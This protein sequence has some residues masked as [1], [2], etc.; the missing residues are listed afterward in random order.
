M[1]GPSIRAQEAEDAL[2]VELVSVDADGSEPVA[3]Q[4]TAPAISDDGGSVA[5]EG[6]DGEA[7]EQRVWIRDR[8]AGTTRA[9]AE[10][11]S[12]APGI[13]G[14]GCVVAYS[15]IGDETTTLTVADV[16]AVADDPISLD[17]VPSV[18]DAE[19]GTAVVAAPAL[20]VDGTVVVWS[21][22]TEIRRYVKSAVSGHYEL[23][24]VFG[25]ALTPAPG[26]ATG[27]DVD[28]TADGATIVYV[29]GPGDAPYEPVPAN[30]HVWDAG[31]PPGEPTIEIVSLTDDGE[32]GASDSSSPSISA[33]GSLVVF[34]STSL[35]L[36]AAVADDAG[37]DDVPFVVAVDRDGSST[38]LLVRSAARPMVS[39]DGDHVVYERDGALRLLSS[40]AGVAFDTHRAPAELAEVA[41]LSRAALSE[42][43]RWL[44]FDATEAPD[45]AS[46]IL[47][48][49]QVWAAD[50][51]PV[52]DTTTTTTTSTTPPPSGSATTSTSTTSTTTTTTSTTTTDPTP[53]PSGSTTEPP[54]SVS[55]PPRFITAVPR[56]VRTSRGTGSSSSTS[57]VLSAGSITF[58]PTVIGVGRRTGSVVLSNRT[59]ST[60]TLSGAS[61]APPGPF[62]ILDDG[63]T[64]RLGAGSSCVVQV[65]FAPTAVGIVT[66][67]LQFQ[68]VGRS[69]VVATLTGEGSPEPTIDVVPAVAGEGQAVTVFGAG[70]PA[71]STVRF[72]RQELPGGVEVTVDDDGTFAH[73]VVVVPNTPTGPTTWTV[74]AEPD[75]FGE[76]TT[77]LLVSNRGS[78]S[79]AAA[80]RGTLTG[81]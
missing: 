11:T 10:P 26:F 31:V 64:G 71:G 51:A 65:E 58:A 77:Q 12:R 66:A 46:A 78:T 7:G 28:V 1:Y 34:A 79:D 4:A 49:T 59:S 30:I 72:V 15:V 22:G 45:G 56:I 69:T 68:V 76:A 3:V 13:S 29:A 17:T 62:A 33:D 5:F 2:V 20:S 75:L 19:T 9:V 25:T 40:S 44:V 27:A 42:S 36:A 35:D 81:G 23:T 61:I 67:S 47:P 60:V 53:S 57:A 8:S 50:T 70:Y 6:S 63:C 74:E 37:D 39:G 24:D 54:P 14:D 52:V 41:P 43:G 55:T 38:Q 48:G 18:V 16:C 21:M 73:I 32:A 80:L